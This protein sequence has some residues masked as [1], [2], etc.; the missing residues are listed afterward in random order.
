MASRRVRIHLTRRACQPF[1]IPAE[2]LRMLIRIA[3]VIDAGF[4][5]LFAAFV[6]ARLWR[7]DL[8]H[9]I[10]MPISVAAF[11]LWMLARQQLGTSFAIKAEARK[12]VTNT[13][14]SKIR[15][16]IYF[17]GGVAY[18]ALFIAAGLYV[19]LLVFLLA[20]THQLFRIRREEKVL[21][22]AFGDE[23]LAYRA[24]TWF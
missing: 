24:R 20:Y 7:N 15:N 8:R 13:L 6:A 3:K 16:P 10:F 12:L 9:W 19:F 4:Y 5:L 1:Q 11:T 23:Y 17:F 21:T 2:F 22:Q 14:Y 18:S